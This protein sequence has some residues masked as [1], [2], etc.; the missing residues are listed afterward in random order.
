M[1]KDAKYSS[2]K[3]PPPP[4]YYSASAQSPRQ[5]NMVFYVADRDGAGASSRARS[6]APWRRSIPNLPI[7]NSRTMQ[8]QIDANIA[9]E[10]LL[11][12]LTG[13]FAGLAT[14]LAAIG[15]Y[16]V[17][18]FNVAR[19]TREIGIR[20]ALGASAPQVRR[21]VVREVVLIIGIGLAVGLGAAGRPGRLIQSILFET[22][23]AD[24]WVFVVRRRRPWRRSRSPPP[25][26]PSGARPGSTP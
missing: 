11:S 16:G 14:L 26:C 3:E 8:A 19:R 12:L 4:V 20:M 13:S 17:L 25:T 22:K 7:V 1:V 6:A 24:P 15:L 18:A 23:P 5:R 21:L 2:M 10:R 9:N